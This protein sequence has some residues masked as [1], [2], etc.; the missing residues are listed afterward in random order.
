MKDVVKRIKRQEPNKNI[1]AKYISDEVLNMYTYEELLKHSNKKRAQ[2]TEKWKHLNRHSSASC[3]AD[4]WV[5]EKKHLSLSSENCALKQEHGLQYPL[6][7]LKSKDS[8]RP[9]LTSMQMNRN[10]HVPWV[11]CKLYGHIRRQQCLI[12]LKVTS[13]YNPAVL[14]NGLDNLHTILQNK[15]C[16]SFMLNCLK[17]KATKISFD[18]I[19]R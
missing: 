8:Q 10:S 5:Q 7:Q 11:E 14:L 19:S 17:L 6:Q 15:V 1:F 9:M 18:K 16:T 3:P 2:A 12:E 4:Q 13:L